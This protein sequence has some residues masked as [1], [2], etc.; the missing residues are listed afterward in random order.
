MNVLK[1]W[2]RSG[3]LAAG[4]VG[5]LVT[6]ACGMGVL[7]AYSNSAGL[8]A[9]APEY[10]PT[11]LSLTREPGG[12]TL[13]V[14]AHPRCPCTRAS[15]GEL[16]RIMARP[17]GPVV[18]HVIFLKPDGFDEDWAKTDLW[19]SATRVPDVRVHRDD[20]GALTRLFGA[21]TSGQVLLY[22][23]DGRLRYNGGITASR[24]HAG[25][26]AGSALVRRLI[27]E[28]DKQHGAEFPVFG[29]PLIASGHSGSCPDRR[30]DG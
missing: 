1:G 28:G 26:N 13:V 17:G 21:A 3:L 12:A 16:Q 18:A 4:G 24:G 20:D 29:C 10:W 15:I 6:V 23:R 22:D 9:E 11:E 2:L 8:S 25:D 14:L 27:A 19:K 5:W 30:S 7:W